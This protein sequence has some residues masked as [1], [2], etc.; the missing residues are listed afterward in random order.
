MKNGPGLDSWAAR[1]VLSIVLSIPFIAVSVWRF[2][3]GDA[4]AGVLFGLVAAGV[5]SIAVQLG[6]LMIRDRRSRP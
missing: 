2:S 6:V 1:V 3:S 4:V 5:L